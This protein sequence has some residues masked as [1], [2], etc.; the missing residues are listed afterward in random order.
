VRFNKIYG[1]G[2]GISISTADNVNE[3]VYVY[4]NLVFGGETGIRAYKYYDNIHFWSNIVHNT[5][6]L[7]L[8]TGYFTGRDQGDM[9]VYN[10]TVARAGDGT[11]YWSGE[12]NEAGYRIN[13]TSP[14]KLYVKNNIFYECDR[15]NTRDAL[16]VYNGAEQYILALNYNTY[17]FPSQTVQFYYKNTRVN[18]DYMKGEGWETNGEEVDPAFTYP[19]GSDDEH[20]TADDDYT[21]SAIGSL[22]ESLS[23]SSLPNYANRITIQTTT[24]CN[25]VTEPDACDELLSYSVGLDPNLTDWTTTPPTVA[26]L[27]RGTYGFARGAYGWTDFFSSS[28]IPANGLSIT[29]N[30][31]EAMYQGSAYNDAHWD[32]DCSLSGNGL[33]MSY[34]SGNGTTSHQYS[35]TGPIRAGETCNVDFTGTANSM[36]NSIGS[37]LVQITDGTVVNNSEVPVFSMAIRRFF[38]D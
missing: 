35:L 34:V 8:W 26:V 18:L 23:D 3:N 21:L 17:Y 5:M 24:Y 19:E 7:G 28:S 33:A 32:L 1:Y 29:L 10:N 37:D 31:T 22:G 36:E 27:D 4:G 9:F 6:G 11:G 20:G 14:L 30:F 12:T 38:M 15:T 13:G 2:T 16:Y 25:D